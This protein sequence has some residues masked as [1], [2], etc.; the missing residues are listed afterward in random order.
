MEGRG[1]GDAPSLRDPG[2]RVSETGRERRGKT[3]GFCGVGGM[4]VDMVG[5]AIVLGGRV[6]IDGLAVGIEVVGLWVVGVVRVE[7]H[8]FVTVIDDAQRGRGMWRGGGGHGG[9]WW[10]DSKWC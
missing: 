1:R 9:W 10:W 2:W 6:L 8:V 5:M 4:V 3:Y 7:V